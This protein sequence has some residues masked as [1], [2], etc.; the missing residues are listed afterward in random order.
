MHGCELRIVKLEGACD[1]PSNMAAD[2]A[3]LNKLDHRSVAARVYG[4]T[5][6]WITLGKFQIPERDLLPGCRVSY[7][8]RPTGGRAVL[9]GHDVTI[10]LAIKLSCFAR[11][12]ESAA[13]I[14]RSVRRAYRGAVGPIIAAMNACGVDACLGEDIKGL[15]AGPKSA[16]CFAHLSANDVVDRRSLKKVCGVAMLLTSDAVLVQASI[17]VDPPLIDPALVYESPSKPTWV[18]MDATAFASELDR[19]LCQL[20]LE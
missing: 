19:A 5:E 20:A 10:G 17:P 7:S 4:W 9:H 12:D 15:Q 14:S 8:M 2:E 1:G 18:E 16:D 13:A 3:L 6:P 11:D